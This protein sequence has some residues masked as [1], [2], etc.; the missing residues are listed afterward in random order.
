MHRMDD[1][2]F[3]DAQQEHTI[4]WKRLP[5][6]AQAGTVCFITWRT[7]DSLPAAVIARLAEERRRVL[8]M[9]GIADGDW[10]HG[11]GKL[12][13]ADR[14]RA[15]WSLFA[16][17]DE[18][19]DDGAGACVLARPELSEIVA[20]SLLHFDGDRYTVTDFVVMPNHVHLLVAFREEDMLLKQCR[21]WKRFTS[22]QIQKALDRRGEFWQVEQFD[23]LVRSPEDFA[24]YRRY[25]AE[26]PEKAH[27]P[28]G[29]YRLYSKPQLKPCEFRRNSPT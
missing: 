21:S 18:Q 6:W 15:Q 17:W 2:Q 25:I 7:A 5:H 10:R 11:L 24:R 8:R 4:A 19:L 23:H 14:R 20:E 22:G 9:F 28:P 27:L 29:S 26:N 1:L 12:P 16:A 13:L 3:F